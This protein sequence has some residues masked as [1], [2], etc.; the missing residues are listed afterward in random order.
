MATLNLNS[1]NVVE[2]RGLRD[3][4]SHQKV[5]TATVTVTLKTTSG[6]EVSGAVWP[7]AMPHVSS[8]TYRAILPHDIGIVAGQTYIGT[9]VADNGT[10]QHFERCVTYSVTC[11]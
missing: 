5:V 8:G 9:V 3:I 4:I 1:N 6:V 11:D 7:L 10:D 2:L